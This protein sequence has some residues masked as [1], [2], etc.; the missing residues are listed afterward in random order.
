M[1]V[2]AISI[3]EALKEYF[4]FEKFKGNQQQIIESIIAR[5]DTLV[6]MPTGGGKSLCYQLPA[7]IS[8]GT[9]II[10]S[11]LIAL[12][13][14]QVDLVRGYSSTDNIAH[15][16]NSQM[17]KA[18]ITQV[19]KD[20]VSGKCKLLYVAPE[21]LV[22]QDNI[23]FLQ[24]IKISFVAVDEAHCISE[25]GHDF[26]P[27]YRKIKSMLNEI[28]DN[29]PIVALTAT[30]TPKVQSDIV[31][32]LGMSA[33]KIFISSFLRDNLYYEVR[34]KP[35]KQDAIKDII[36]YI[37]KEGN[38]SGIIYCLSRNSTEEL[39]EALQV[40][41]INAA[42]Y[43]AGLDAA[44]RSER[45]DQFLMEDVQVIVATIAFGMGIDKPDVRFV[46][47]FDIPKSLENYYQET[48][49]AGR[50][51]LEG[52][53]IAYF[54]PKEIHKFEKFI[55]SNKEKTVAE[56]EIAV[57]QL[58][59]VE[60]YSES[61]EC[62]KK[63]VLHYF[64]EDMKNCGRCDNCLHPKEQIEA[65][66]EIKLALQT[67]ADTNEKINIPNTI[68]ILT[69]RK[70]ADITA[71]NLDKLKIFGKGA[72][73]DMVFWNSVVRKAILLNLLEKDIE[74][75]G[76][77]KL[78]EE[79]KKFIKKPSSAKIVLNHKFEDG[80]DDDDTIQLNGK[81]GNVLEP[82]LL[83]I[84]KGVRKSVGEKMKLPPYTI[85]SEQS[86]EEMATFFPFSVEELSKIHGVNPAKAIKF[87][88]QFLEAIKKYV[89]ENDIERNADFSVIKTAD[90]N[91]N[92]KVNIIKSIDKK[93]PLEHIASSYGLNMEDLITELDSIVH[94]GTKVNINYYLEDAVDEDI[95]EEIFDYFMQAEND[96][97]DVAYKKL[98]AE[99][100]ELREIQLVRLKFL[101][102]VAN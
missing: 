5:K 63:F 31:R 25:W 67:V 22:K 33:P 74:Q 62:R 9:A 70:S 90:K 72:E 93:M 44:V 48:G 57:M 1:S 8:E 85:F 14:N 28:E 80:E 29:I 99:D 19:K 76:V 102:D 24:T 81:A 7:I 40:N 13:K 52:N 21:S 84:L 91:S 23:D 30:A 65:K 61:A 53:C 32:T 38:K 54:S 64:G 50:D 83:E 41:G 97:I 37:K 34:P 17:N 71:N 35:S 82:Q 56:K 18:Q 87:G 88:N 27:E 45:Q 95:Q 43:H 78:T 51:G 36:K 55:L 26:R 6:I 96:D 66:D 98:K 58:S 101:S 4:G 89:E 86:L 47:H 69:G 49:R 2:Q 10:V 15:F 20:I 77:L 3:S 16:I 59:E 46:I 94:A 100:I 75:Y 39:A 11:P 92:V 68:N 60:A 73:K 12:M 79:G 42:A